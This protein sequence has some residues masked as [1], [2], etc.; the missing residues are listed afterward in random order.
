MR[1]VLSGKSRPADMN[2]PLASNVKPWRWFLPV[3]FTYRCC[4]MW[5]DERKFKKVLLFSIKNCLR[6]QNAGPNH[7]TFLNLCFNER[8]V[9]DVLFFTWTSINKSHKKKTKTWTP[10]CGHKMEKQWH[11]LFKKWKYRYSLYKKIHPKREL[12]CWTS[13]NIFLSKI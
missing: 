7:Q 2:S 9:F 10:A 13:A 6:E 4:F 12:T 5:K 11:D 3:L 1:G 8:S